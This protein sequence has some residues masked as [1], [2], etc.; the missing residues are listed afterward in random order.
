MFNIGDYA[1]IHYHGSKIPATGSPVDNLEGTLVKITE[2]IEQNESYI[3]HFEV[4]S[5]CCKDKKSFD[6]MQC[7]FM[8]DDTHLI[9]AEPDMEIDTSSLFS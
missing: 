4:V 6:K 1:I 5:L 9:P 2:K 3:Y 7:K 8:W